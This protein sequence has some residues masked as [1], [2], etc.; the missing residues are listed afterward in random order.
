M[1]VLL[2]TVALFFI[3]SIS[4]AE[5]PDEYLEPEVTI[6]QEDDQKVE[7]YRIGG[8]LYMIKITPKN[9]PPYYLMDTDGDGD[10]ETRR[11]DSDSAIVGPSWKLFSW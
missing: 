8:K 1:R 4:F 2:I 5:S 3:G 6:I 10:L 11:D 7:E 9:A